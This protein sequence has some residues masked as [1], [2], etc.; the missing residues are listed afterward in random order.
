MDLYEQFRV[1]RDLGQLTVPG[2]TGDHLII[3]DDLAAAA[4]HRR[5]RKSH[6]PFIPRGQ[7]RG[8]QRPGRPAEGGGKAQPGARVDDL[9]HRDQRAGTVPLDERGM[10]VLPGREPGRVRSQPGQR[11]CG[12]LCLTCH[13]CRQ[14]DPGIQPHINHDRRITGNRYTAYLAG[15][16]GAAVPALGR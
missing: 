9:Q 11:R 4:D 12:G 6:E 8:G 14:H 7:G 3:Q 13:R 15:Q 2:K 10:V 5:I 16:A 1:R